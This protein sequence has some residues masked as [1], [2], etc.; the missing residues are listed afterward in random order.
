MKFNLSLLALALLLLL[1][2]CSNKSAS[3]S[4]LS[5]D[6]RV[7]V[8]L[9]DY[10]SF[11]NT[12][13]IAGVTG[14]VIAGIG[15]G[16]PAVALGAA[17]GIAGIYQWHHYN[18]E[19]LEIE[20][21]LLNKDS[22]IYKELIV[23]ES[24]IKESGRFDYISV[25]DLNILEHYNKSMTKH[26][27]LKD[28]MNRNKLDYIL[29]VTIGKY[30]NGIEISWRMFDK[31]MNEVAYIETNEKSKDDAVDFTRLLVKSTQVFLSEL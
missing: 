13:V 14:G 24:V 30:F 5:N 9:I 8:A 12:E 27:K 17:A 21:L 15:S 18:N 6:K 26:S 25:D 29:T 16:N 2:G 19:S 22:E 10:K 7:S 28:F 3:V 20:K 4:S 1:S 31:E 23:V 11:S